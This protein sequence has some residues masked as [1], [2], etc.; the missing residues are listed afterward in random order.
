MKVN[1]KHTRS[2][3]LEADGRSVGIIDQTL[4]PHRFATVRL[5][6]LEDAARRHQ[7]HADARRAADRRDGGLRRLPGAARGRIGR[8]AGARLC[9]AAR[10]APDRDQP[11]MGAGRDAWRRCATGR[12]RSG[13]PRPIGAR[14]KSATR[15]SPSTRPSAG[16]VC[17]LIEEIAAQEKPGEPVNVLTHCNAGWL[18]TVDWGTATAPIYAGARQGHPGPCLGRRDAAAQPG[19]L[20]HR[21]GARP[22][23]RAAHRDPGQYRR[24]SDAARR[25]RHRDRRHRPGHRATA[26]SATRS[27]PI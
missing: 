24:T 14:P 19:R 18:A 22:A 5:A 6:T 4:L 17:K 15:T 12:A 27:A 3:W 26:M 8:S 7:L 10:D 1:G 2:I 9:R 21:V 16:T 25:G 11:E 20:A 13:S 23:R